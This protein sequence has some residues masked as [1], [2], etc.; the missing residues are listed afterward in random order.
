MLKN[1]ISLIGIQPD[2]T[3][4]KEKIISGLGS[5]LAIFLIL[6]VSRYFIGT[7]GSA[8]IVASMGASAV[9][10]FAVPHGPLS[11]PWPVAGG[12]LI[13]AFLGVSCYLIVNDVTIAAA[14]AVSLSILAMYYLRCIHPPGGATALT[15]VLGGSVIND[16]GYSF[17]LTPVL[18]NVVI[19]LAVA[20]LFNYPFS[21]RRY[22]VA[23]INMQKE[24]NKDKQS[25]IIAK[26]DLQYALESINSFMDISAIEL[27]KI[28]QTASQ[29]HIDKQFIPQQIILG[30]YYLHGKNDDNGVIRR[31]IDESNDQ[32]D[33]VIYKIITG[34][35]KKKTA[36]MSRQQF[37][38]WAKHEVVFIN[39][40]WEIIL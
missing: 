23:F 26:E 2:N 8:L 1:L 25:A 32:Q 33:M 24:K 27:E 15:A 21:W 5:F 11:Q 35:Q 12:H 10:L 19:I 40:Q 17:M 31:I 39:E 20:V 4:H 7:E 9:L 34:P 13:S 37:A 6:I 29:R 38:K 30:H 16:L 14:L 3:Q 36:V 28:Y 18:I 22:P